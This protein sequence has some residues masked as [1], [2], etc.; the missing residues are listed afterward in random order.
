MA[1]LENGADAAGAWLRGR[2]AARRRARGRLEVASLC[3]AATFLLLIPL[4]WQAPLR[5]L[6]N[7]S[8]SA[9]VGLYQVR[10]TNGLRAGDMVVARTPD[11]ARSLAAGRGYI[12]SNV[13]LVK[14]IAA[15]SGDRV[16]ASGPTLTV[17]G[18]AAARRRAADGLGRPMPR[19]TGCHLLAEGEY[20]LLTDSPGSFDGRY[21]GVTRQ[22]QLLGRAT[23]LWLA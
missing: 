23:P 9:P 21:F 11:P 7:A 17:N 2:L 10:G 18:K 1:E 4:H 14:R 8:A 5:L 3:L 12:P 13:P 16:C 19:W 15:V 22:H 6:W 20:L